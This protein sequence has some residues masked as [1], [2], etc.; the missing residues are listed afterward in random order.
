MDVIPDNN[1]SA[2]GKKVKMMFDVK[3]GVNGTR[4]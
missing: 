1:P 3:G 4:A 2:I